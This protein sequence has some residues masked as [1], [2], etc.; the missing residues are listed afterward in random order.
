MPVWDSDERERE[1]ERERRGE[2][3]RRGRWRER[4]RERESPLTVRGAADTV[5]V[6]GVGVIVHVLFGGPR[7]PQRVAE[8]ELSAADRGHTVTGDTDDTDDR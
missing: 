8:M 2:E 5:E 4:E 3:V 6:L 1:R 7:Q